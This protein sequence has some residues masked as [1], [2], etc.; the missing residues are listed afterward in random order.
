[1]K[2]LRSN[3]RITE[4]NSTADSLVRLYKSYSVVAEDE[5]L[6]DVMGETENLSSRITT[7]IKRDRI[8]STLSAADSKR[9]SNIR[10]IGTLLKGYS[11]FPND[12]KKSAAERLLATF[13]KYKGITSESY[14]NKTSLIASMLEDYASDSLKGQVDLLDGISTLLSNLRSAQNE[15]N[16]AN[17][18][19]TAA[20]ATKSESASSLKKPLLNAINNKL[21]PYLTAMSLSNDEMY[22]EFSVKADAEIERVNAAVA[23][24]CKPTSQ[25]S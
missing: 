18:E 10:A 25:E 5:Y 16:S 9:D 2:K 17:D 1:M 24:R 8:A 15:F 21:V 23:K 14:A 7:A 22:G 19:F 12:L 11:V 13:G 6:K 4:L 3:A 20:S